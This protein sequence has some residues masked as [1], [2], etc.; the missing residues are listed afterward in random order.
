MSFNQPA[1]NARILAAIGIA[2]AAPSFVLN[3]IAHDGVLPSENLDRTDGAFSLMLMAGAAFVVAALFAVRPSPLGRIG[4]RLLVVEAVM[5]TLAAVW[6]ALLMV[7]PAIVEDPNPLV[8]ICDACWPLH[9]VFMIVV[10][11]AAVRAAHWPKPE[12]FSL[13]GPAVGLLILGIGAGTGVDLLAAVG[14][15]LGWTIAGA[16]VIAVTSER[17]PAAILDDVDVLAVAGVQ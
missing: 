3:V 7:D 17:R 16:G 5:V 12:R 8:A 15:G 10:G 11:I 14:I 4:R 6:A 1:L 9:Q 13:F 2:L